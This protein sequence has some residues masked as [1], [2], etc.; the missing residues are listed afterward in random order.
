[1]S[2]WSERAVDAARVGGVAER[3]GGSA[4]SVFVSE[5]LVRRVSWVVLPGVRKGAL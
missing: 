2:G 4:V 3:Q 5:P 1:V